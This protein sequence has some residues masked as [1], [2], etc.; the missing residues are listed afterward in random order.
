MA[1]LAVRS[2]ASVMNAGITDA[3]TPINVKQLRVTNFM[4][5]LVMCMLLPWIPV[6]A[7]AR[8]ELALGA[9]I[10]AAT[11]LLSVILLNRHGRY[12]AATCVLMITAHLQLLWTNWVTGYPS[13]TWFYY[14]PM[15]F[16]PFVVFRREHRCL[17]LAFSAVAALCFL[18]IFTFQRYFPAR[19]TLIDEQASSLVNSVAAIGCFVA[20]AMVFMD[21]VDDTEDALD[22][23]RA[24]SDALLLNVL[25]ASI[26]KRLKKSP[27]AVIA[28]RCGEVTVLFADIVGFTALSSKTNPAETVKM[29]NQI[30]TV[31]DELCEVHGVERIKTIGDGYMAF[32]G[33]SDPPPDHATAMLKVAIGMRDYLESRPFAEPL[34][35]RIGL[36]SGEVVAGIVGTTRFHYDIWGDAVNVASRME[37]T[38]EPGRI[39]IARSTWEKIHDVYP[40]EPRGRIPVKGKGQLETW[41]VR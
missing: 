30:F 39:H 5:L 23:Q 28:D 37:S 32:S 33:A 13:G 1:G 21:A 4:A 19:I 16:V 15:V 6:A 35:V 9:N 14:A 29:L 18:G 31:F 38:G 25:P 20:L 12:F 27:D 40:C 8:E 7:I 26:A 17:A 3:T 36:N 22:R 41:F 24:Q 11:V 34:Q 2:L 10:V